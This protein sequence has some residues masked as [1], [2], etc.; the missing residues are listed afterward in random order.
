MRLILLDL[1]CGQG[2]GWEE[3]AQEQKVS[4][5]IYQWDMLDTEQKRQEFLEKLDTWCREEQVA[6]LFGSRGMNKTQEEFLTA[7]Q[8]EMLL[9]PV[10]SEALL[11]N[12]GN[13]KKE[14]I[15]TINE[16]LLYGGDENL[17]RCVSYI[18]HWLFLEEGAPI[19]EEPCRLP[20]DGI[21]GVRTG[22]VYQDVTA[23]LE[24]EEAGYETYVGIMSHRSS[25]VSQTLQAEEALIGAFHELGIGVIPVFSAGETGETIRSYGFEELV[26]H[27]F[28]Q[29]GKVL[30]QGLVQFQM[31]LIKGA[32]GLSASEN[33]VRM[34]CKYDVPVFHPV[35]TYFVTTETWEEET[36]PLAEEMQSAYLNPEMA[37]MTEPVLIALRSPRER[38]IVLQP[39]SIKGLARRVKSWIALRTTPNSRKKIALILHNSVCAGVEATIGK[40]FGL[41]ALESA[42][43]ILKR[44]KKEGYQVEQIP[45]DGKALLKLILEKKAFSDF[46]WTSVED[47]LQSGGCLYRMSAQGEYQEYFQ[48]FTPR[49]RE[50]LRKAWGDPPGEGMVQG[51]DLIITGLS[52]GNVCLLVQ[53]KRGCYGAKCTGE[54]CRILHDPNCP[55]THQY[56]ATYRYL[57]RVRQ[58]HAVVH[59][60]TDGSLEYLPGKGSGLGQECWPYAVLGSMPNLY[61]Y[62]IGVTS[63]GCIAK[64]RANAVLFGYYP[65]SSGG[66][67]AEEL[68]L[69][70]QIQAY[71]E[72]VQMKN[73]QGTAFRE[74]ILEL[75]EEKEAMRG[76]LNSAETFE[77]GISLVRDALLASAES[78]KLSRLHVFGENPDEEEI[79]GYLTE[80]LLA[81]QVLER[82]ANESA[83]DYQRRVR[84]VVEECLRSTDTGGLLGEDIRRVYRLLLCTKQE[85]DLLVHGLNGGFIPSSEGGMPDENGRRILPTGRNFYQMN[86]DKIPD[87]VAYERGSELAKQLL[88]TYLKDAGAYPKKI[89]MNMISLDIARTHGEQLSQFLYLLGVRPV[90]DRQGRVIGLKEIPVSELGRPR[91]D[92]T[93]RISGVMRDTWPDAVNLMD[94]AVLLAAS[95]PESEEEN[96]ILANTHEM[97]RECGELGKRAGTIRI[98]GDPPGT[99]GAGL[100]LALKASAW[101]TDEDLARYFIQASAFAYGNGLNGRS[102]I[103]EFVQNVKKIDLSCDLSSS[104]RNDSLSC[105]FG[106]QVQGGFRLA[107]K[108]IGKKE[109]R[110]YQSYSEKNQPMETLA[111]GE[112]VERDIRQTLLNPVWQDRTREEGY[113]GAGEMMSRMQRVFEAKCMNDCVSDA[114]L[115]QLAETYVNQEEMREWLLGQNP[116]AAEEIAR[117]LLELESRGRWK[118]QE[119]VLQALREDYLR[120]E[121]CMEDEAGGN[122]EIQ[123]GSVE[124]VRDEQVEGWRENLQEIDA[125]LNTLEGRL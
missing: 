68:R 33:S 44:L 101:E 97:E 93:L 11:L 4:L 47:I 85:M 61:P 35:S 123:G 26:E 95:L 48:E 125:Y 40:A 104:R 120:I 92:V 2:S 108:M 50:A 112:S 24:K 67:D 121:G 103:R 113:R 62:H 39:E 78:G 91:I 109:I 28:C 88:E 75:L 34:F 23:F 82:R 65:A 1:F 70:D 119:E 42:V 107:A 3:A 7:L 58:V 90:W 51:G 30:I 105:G 72:A 27:Y 99:Y 83:F 17:R 49:M 43:A 15:T 41:D 118:P 89:A 55:P 102:S 80:L 21:Y 63:E 16:Y 54:V 9:V 79:L 110:Q 10:G 87:P 8:G 6:L 71:E 45:E 59:I 25:W 116:Y 124:I 100:D 38:K 12:Q 53:P 115:D 76:L 122:G 106:V 22:E 111:L 81:D 52:F 66:F 114:V 96:Y 5:C 74:R 94:E 117:R 57:E 77:E 69:M 37:G 19:P 84:E 36:N 29:D 20:F 60:G 14:F 31:H 73:G 18:R 46:R 32:D 86:M 98:F 13:V 64:R 56:I